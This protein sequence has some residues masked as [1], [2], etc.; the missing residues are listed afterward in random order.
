MLKK[1]ERVDFTNSINNGVA[2][3]SI[4]AK[5]LEIEIETVR[6]AIGKAIDSRTMAMNAAADYI[7][8]I[9]IS[10]DSAAKVAA[11]NTDVQAK[12]MS[13][14]G[15]FY[16]VRLSRDELILKSKLAELDNSID[17]YKH[18]RTNA[19]DNDR[20]KVQALTAAA[21]VLGGAAKAAL[22]SLN[23]VASTAVNAFS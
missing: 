4:A 18:R 6:F 8:A 19:T 22:S 2:S 5:Q 9:A 10:P 17:I 13:A 16:R 14:A 20:V 7:R 11:L 15:D 1:I 23:S 21:D 3:T 12:M